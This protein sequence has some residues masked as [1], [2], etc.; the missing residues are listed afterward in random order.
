MAI[1]RLSYAALLPYR[2]VILQELMLILIIFIFNFFTAINNNGPPFVITKVIMSHHV[3]AGI[4]NEEPCSRLQG[5]IKLT[6][7]GSY[8]ISIIR[9]L[10]INN[11]YFEVAIIL[12]QR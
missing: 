11:D 10:I 6:I 3:N 7:D 5:I 12:S 9:G 8:T 4:W 1:L 2:N